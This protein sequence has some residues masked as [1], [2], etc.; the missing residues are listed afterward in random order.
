MPLVSNPEFAD[1]CVVF[2][3][4]NLVGRCEGGP[5]GTLTNDQ[6]YP[7]NAV[8]IGL[9]KIRAAANYAGLASGKRVCIAL[10]AQENRG[11]RQAH[12]PNYKGKR[13]SKAHLILDV[14]WH[15]GENRRVQY[16]GVRDLMELMQYIP[17]LT[18]AMPKNNGETD[19]A[20]AS[21][22]HEVKVP[23]VV[24]TEDRDMWSLM[25]DRVEIISKPEKLFNLDN[26]KATFG[27]DEPRKL[28]LAKALYGDGSD[29]IEKAVSQVTDRV[30]GEE[31]R[32]CQKLP[33]EKQYAQG[34][35]REIASRR[36]EKLIAALFEKQSDIEF[37]E[38]WIRLRK[39]ELVYRYGSRNLQQLEKLLSWYGINKKKAGFL[40]F[41]QS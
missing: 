13:P 24:V 7:T 41:A 5:M 15:T 12:Y 28:A 9:S 1:K 14:N 36:K 30:I 23:C 26:L 34:F 29:C 4:H 35:F 32:R 27:I 33:G 31:L 40:A 21:F 18:M 38:L 2:D 10:S 17:S 6:N 19:D 22:V 3:V 16:D 39:V 11:V 25:S 8:D 20:I 37:A